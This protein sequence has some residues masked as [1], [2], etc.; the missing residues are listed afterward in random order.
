[1]LTE[2]N[3]VTFEN[4]NQYYNYVLTYTYQCVS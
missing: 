3:T 1:M 4:K 2:F